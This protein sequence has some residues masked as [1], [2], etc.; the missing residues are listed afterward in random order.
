M[1][2]LKKILEGR[3]IRKTLLK[4]MENATWTGPCPTSIAP[5]RGVSGSQLINQGDPVTVTKDT[6]NNSLILT[7][8]GKGTPHKIVFIDEKSFKR[9]MWKTIFVW[10]SDVTADQEPS[11]IQGVS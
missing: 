6:S 1:N 4:Y 8:S 7:V 11:A 10:G 9:S 5:E 2:V 3:N